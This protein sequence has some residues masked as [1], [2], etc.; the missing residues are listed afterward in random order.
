MTTFEVTPSVEIATNGWQDITDAVFST[1]QES[2]TIEHGNQG[3]NQGLGEPSSCSLTFI[4]PDLSTDNPNSPH[5]GLLGSNTRIRVA[6]T[7]FAHTFPGT[8][9]D[10]WSTVGGF[11]VTNTGAGGVV[12]ASDWQQTPG[13]GTHS[14]PG[15]SQYR[16]TVLQDYGQEDGEQAISFRLPTANVTGGGL[17]PANLICQWGVDNY[18]I[19]LRV[20][21]Q[22][23]ESITMKFMHTG[24]LDL[25]DEF[26][27]ANVVNTGQWIR[28]KTNVE[29]RRLQAKAWSE[30]TDDEPLEWTVNAATITSQWQ[31]SRRGGIGVRTGVASGNTNAAPHVV[32]YRNWTA[33]TILF[34]GGMSDNE[35]EPVEGSD[36]EVRIP[37]VANGRSRQ[38]NQG[39]LPVVSVLRRSIPTHA[40]LVAYWPMEDE[41]SSTQFASGLPGHP[42]LVPLHGTPGYAEYNALDCSLPLPTGNLSDWAGPVPAYT[43]TGIIQLRFVLHCPSTPM[44]DRAILLR[45]YTDHPTSKLWQLV[46]RTSSGGSLEIQAWNSETDSVYVTG[47]GIDALDN[48][49]RRISFEL[50]NS[51]ANVAW[52]LNE[53][54]FDVTIAGSTDSGTAAGLQLTT[55]KRVWVN[56]G[57]MDDLAFGHLELQNQITDF[58]V[59]L[60]TE[61]IAFSGDTE[62]DRLDRVYGDNDIDF[63]PTDEP[64]GFR[65]EYRMGP[66]QAENMTTLL[67]EAVTLNSGGIVYDARAHDGMM[68]CDRYSLY[69]A[70]PH[71]ELT[72]AQLSAPFT[73]R[74]DDRD[75]RNRITVK[76]D[77]GSSGTYE[78]T[79]GR[80]STLPPD[81]GGVGLY[82]ST[83]TV[84]KEDDE[85]LQ[86]IAAWRV[87]V[88]TV[89]EPRYS[90]ATI[91]LGAA[92]VV[93]APTIRARLRDLRPGHLVT[94]TGADKIYAYDTIWQHVAGYKITLTQ[95]RLSYDLNTVPHLPYR[96]FEVEDSE[97][98]RLD[99]RSTTLAAA[100]NSVAT[101]FQVDSPAAVWT[102]DPA[103]FPFDLAIGGERMIVNDINGTVPAYIAT[104]TAA[105][106]DN[107][108]VS[109]GVPGGATGAGNDMLM[110]TQGRG[111]RPA[112]QP[113]GWSTVATFG[114]I[115]L[116]RK[117]HSGSESAPTVSWSTGS[118]GDTNSAV[119]TS[120][121]NLGDLIATATA[122][123]GG[124]QNIP[125]AA[126]AGTIADGVA[127]TVGVKTD[128]W[129]GV[130]TRAGCTEIVDTSTT[131]GSDQGVVVDYVT[132]NGSVSGLPT[133]HTV[134]AQFV[135]TGGTTGGVASLVA[136]FG[137]RQ[138]FDVDRS[139][140]TVVK[141]HATGAPVHIFNPPR[142]AL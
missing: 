137:N 57:R 17:E 136:V 119:T 141:S 27:C 104:G 112:T 95:F 59:D 28:V 65:F 115:R 60:L 7:I 78:L 52:T 58:F 121:S 126:A 15:T 102:T 82:P 134:P 4:D 124:V 132:H 48:S 10:S 43:D 113:T 85:E 24:S 26:T 123:G 6:D 38:Y 31:R 77:G 69:E 86:Q 100:L 70:T 91:E 2:I 33:R 111:S 39:Q 106:A 118:A 98:G 80:K 32:E 19:L 92:E 16:M 23:D 47:T 61:T 49:V 12:A 37:I 53:F 14:C 55:V 84:N 107:A 68:W 120:W 79:S 40:G 99:S 81:E 127:V 29:N 18:Y 25:T 66:Q 9:V 74:R 63:T 42:P 139:D 130:A 83:V 138:T 8:V 101:T 13:V 133:L 67:E 94:I 87:G 93:A 128:D 90:T 97:R 129:T 125:V 89:D 64:A 71:L 30:D 140:N 122:S 50:Q 1:G 22:T 62:R 96:V 45:F 109:P 135:V 5:Y 108:S 72:Y 73:A 131:A 11:A 116:F 142:W 46:Y 35:L 44:S 103:M 56:T 110:I 3:M 51:G 54:P 117:T 36:G 41:A 34:H 76:R 75:I 114:G 105:H 20:V 88:G 21:V